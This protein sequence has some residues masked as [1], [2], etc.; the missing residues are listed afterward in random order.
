[1]ARES[2]YKINSKLEMGAEKCSLVIKRRESSKE[3]LLLR[4]HQS[5]LKK[6]FF[7][8]GKNFLDR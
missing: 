7:K 6:L 8:P 4:I 1:M 2:K 5:I 3:V